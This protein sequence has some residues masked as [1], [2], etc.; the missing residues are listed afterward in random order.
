MTAPPAF[1]RRYA[2]PAVPVGRVAPVSAPTAETET[3]HD[4]VAAWTGS[5][6]DFTA[7]SRSRRPGR[8]LAWVA[9]FALMASGA[10]CFVARAPAEVSGAL[11]LGGLIA[12]ALLRRARRRRLAAIRD[13]DDGAL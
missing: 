11:E 7:W 3:F 10:L 9:T 8:I 4:E 2:P 12:G 6:S 1:G 5:A 13:W